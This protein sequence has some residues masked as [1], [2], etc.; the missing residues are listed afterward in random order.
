V[1]PLQKARFFS[2]HGRLPHVDESLDAPVAASEPPAE[3]LH[4]G[5]TGES[6][7]PGV[8]LTRE[9]EQPV[10]VRGRRGAAHV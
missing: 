5:N 10:R 1:S 7:P 4:R 8:T 6:Y 3:Q 2:K 9:P